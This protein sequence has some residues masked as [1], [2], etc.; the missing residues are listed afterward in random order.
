MEGDMV[1]Y[2][3]VTKSGG[4]D[5]PRTE[6]IPEGKFRMWKLPHLHQPLEPSYWN[7]WSTRCILE[8]PVS[9]EWL[10]IKQPHCLLDDTRILQGYYKDMIL[11]QFLFWTTYTAAASFYYLLTKTES[12]IFTPL[13]GQPCTIFWQWKSSSA[14]GTTCHQVHTH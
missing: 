3:L 13:S 8:Q 11:L 5:S 7:L 2:V 12:P 10:R 1:V 6:P 4:T 14:F 9:Q